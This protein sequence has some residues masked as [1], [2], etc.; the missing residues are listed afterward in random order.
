M[1]LWLL[2]DGLL[3]CRVVYLGL[4]WL[5]MESDLFGIIFW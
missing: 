4:V 1:R 5:L 2:T 3:N